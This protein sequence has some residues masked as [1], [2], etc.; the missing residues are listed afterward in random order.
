M[1]TTILQ[2]GEVLP[3]TW[4]QEEDS[5]LWIHIKNYG[6]RLALHLPALPVCSVILILTISI[7]IFYL[8]APSSKRKASEQ[9]QRWRRQQLINRFHSF[10]C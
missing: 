10:H 5:F 4:I 8:P 9:E 2:G 6:Y 7:V 3:V 1:T